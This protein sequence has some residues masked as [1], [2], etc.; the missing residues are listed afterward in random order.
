MGLRF[1]PAGTGQVS[2]SLGSD[3]TVEQRATRTLPA[4]SGVQATMLASPILGN[5]SRSA[6]EVAAQALAG[7]TMGGI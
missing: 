1:I 7:W 3:P 2:L 4:N 6:K 5:E